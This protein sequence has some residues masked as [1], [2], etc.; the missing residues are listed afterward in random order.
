[1]D[2][3]HR[4][5]LGPSQVW[6]RPSWTATR[7]GALCDGWL[8]KQLGS[9]QR[10][11]ALC[12]PGSTRASSARQAHAVALDGREEAGD[13]LALIHLLRRKVLGHSIQQRLAA[14]GTLLGLRGVARQAGGGG[15]G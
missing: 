13:D 12:A 7:V 4:E 8:R 2:F 5:G 6:P 15:Q 9:A 14:G 1:M 10:C 3:I 11:V